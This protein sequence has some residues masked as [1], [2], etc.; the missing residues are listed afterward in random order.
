M[1]WLVARDTRRIRPPVDR[2]EQLKKLSW[3]RR[4]NAA[5]IARHAGM[6]RL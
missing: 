6:V 4:L 1:V 3:R 2:Y 5:V